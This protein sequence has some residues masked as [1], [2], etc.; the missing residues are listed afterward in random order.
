MHKKEG[1][2]M[3]KTKIG[4]PAGAVAAIGYL[5][6]LFGGYTAGLLFVGYAVLCEE[7]A[8]LRRSAV[9]ALLVAL[10]FSALS[11]LVGLLPDVVN[12]FSSLLRVF[13]LYIGLE[14]VDSIYFFL[15]NVL[16]LLKTVVFVLLAVLAFKKKTVQ[17]KQ[18]DKL[19]D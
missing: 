12:L 3:E 8:W 14:V 18:L 16:S 2:I 19:F 1:H 9:K 4:L 6:F 5:L 11:L 17:I 7:D 13:R 10:C 15:T